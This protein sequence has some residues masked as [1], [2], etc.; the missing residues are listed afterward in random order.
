ME[1]SGNDKG[2]EIGVGREHGEDRDNLK[3]MSELIEKEV[4]EVAE[5]VSVVSNPTD[6]SSLIIF[7]NA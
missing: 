2:H 3:E 4:I 1:K 5:K 6:I 7:L